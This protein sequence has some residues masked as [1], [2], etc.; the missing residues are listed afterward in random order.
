LAAIADLTTNEALFHRVVPQDQTFEKGKYSG[1]FRFY[2]W[3]FG[4]WVEVLVDDR[5]ATHNGKLIYMTSEERNEFWSSLLEKAYAKLCGSYEALSG[6]LMSESF[7]D[8]TGGMAFKVELRSKAPADLFSKMIMAFDKG[9]LLGC[10]IDSGASTRENMQAN[11]LIIGHAYSITYVTYVEIAHKKDKVALV[12]IRNPW[13]DEHEWNRAWSDKSTEWSQ[14]SE[15]EK[16]RLGFITGK[17]SEDGEFWMSYEDFVR[18]FERLEFCLLGPDS[19][20]N[21]GALYKKPWEG[22]LLQGSWKRR[23]NAGGCRNYPE[24]FWT[25]PQYKIHVTA[26]KEGNGVQGTIIIGLMQI[27]MR[28]M[29]KDGKEDLSIGY[30]IYKLTDP[31]CGTLGRS[32]FDKQKVVAKSS[33]FSDLREVAEF[34]KLDEG[35]YVIVPSTFEQNMEGDFIIR[36]FHEKKEHGLKEMDDDPHST[37][38]EKLPSV[39]ADTAADAKKEEEF[40]EEFKRATHGL[41]G[42]KAQIDAYQLKPI[43]TKL[44]AKE[45]HVTEFNTELCRSLVALHDINMTGKLS[46]DEYKELYKDF[47]VIQKVFK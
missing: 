41:V 23:V 31:N 12:R 20:C 24:T 33:V 38:V 2:F 35:D 44:Y 6:G 27:G 39:N 14:V 1:V 9:A 26:D 4:R 10:S 21:T 29:R 16:K 46:F 7:E 25:N 5:L 15:T 22:T 18:E 13:G 17:K 37:E 19:D 36:V 30:Y 3:Q 8:F 32:F 40:Y 42:S 28:A 11:G 34:H 45:L 43:L 47:H